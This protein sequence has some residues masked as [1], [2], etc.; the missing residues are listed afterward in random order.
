MVI[1]TARCRRVAF[2]YSLSSRQW[3]EK[4]LRK[5]DKDGGNMRKSL[6]VTSIVVSVLAVGFAAVA[7]R[8]GKFGMS[9]KLSVPYEQAVAKVKDA[10]KAEGFG[11]ITEIDVQ[12]SFKEK[13]GVD[14]PKYLI[15]GACNPTMAHRALRIEPEVGLLLPCNVIVYEKDGGVV[16]SAIDPT[17]RLG[18]YDN[19]QLKSV[20]KEVSERLARVIEQVKSS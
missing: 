11:V 16:I 2:P 20:A 8:Q 6:V 3:E 17:A 12:K 18:E 15:I 19:A 5:I 9:V 10:L 13:L 7:Q 4:E 1:G 14:F